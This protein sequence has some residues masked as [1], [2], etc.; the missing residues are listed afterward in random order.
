MNR[1]AFLLGLG[2]TSLLL[3]PILVT[4]QAPQAAQSP[5]GDLAGDCATCHTAEGWSPLRKP[6]LFDHQGTGF[7]LVAAH[8]QA[9]CRACHQSLVFSQ[10][11]TACADCH[12]DAHR[13]EMGPECDTCHTPESWT[14]RREAF[15]IHSRT[16]FP[17]LGAHAGLDCESCHRGAQPREFTGLTPE[18]VSCHLP[19]YQTADN[20]DHDRLG[21]SQQC[22][23]CHSP[24]SRAWQGGT[25]GAG[26]P[27]P[28]TFPLTG[29][30]TRVPCSQCHVNGRFAGTPQQCA[31]CHQD[32]FDRTSNPNHRSAGFPT[33]C[34][35]CHSTEQW[36]GATVD[37]NLTRFPLTGAHVGVQCARCHVGGRFAG[38]PTDCFACHQD[39]FNRAQPNHTT[40]GFGTNCANCHSTT[41]WEGANINHNQTRFPLTG[42]HVGVNCARCHVNGRFAGTPTDCFSCHQDDYNRA[43][44]D[45]RASGFPTTCQNC[46]G[47]NRWEGATFNHPFPLSG[48]HGNI[49]CTT[50]HTNG[51]NFRV[52]DCTNCHAHTRSEMDDKHRGVNGYQYNSAAC[53]RCHPNGRE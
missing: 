5:H 12:R 23:E 35:N 11:P 17:L 36:P 8:A 50:C 32:D 53:Y 37:H 51:N 14:N 39:D 13:G 33:T 48:D 7:P 19:D 26:F 18:C 30:H 46:H 4:A 42:A 22:D 29:A 43:Q 28:D 1:R 38:T 52:F 2:L 10:V 15:R 45:H 40:A 31:A 25:F 3:A 34:E 49:G 9:G 27:H 20:P 41:G 6:V 24:A 44:P 16:R 47:T 21:F